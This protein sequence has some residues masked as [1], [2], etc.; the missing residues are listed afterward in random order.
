VISGQC[1]KKNCYALIVTIQTDKNEENK[2]N[3]NNNFVIEIFI[4]LEI[5]DWSQTNTAQSRCSR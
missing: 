2:T 4:E 3:K 5:G 1:K